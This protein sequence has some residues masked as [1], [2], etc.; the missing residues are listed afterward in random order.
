MSSS[1]AS[2]SRKTGD[3]SFNIVETELPASIILQ[4]TSDTSN[5]HTDTRSPQS[6]RSTVQ[7]RAQLLKLRRPGV[8]R[9]S[10]T[11]L[12]LHWQPLFTAASYNHN[13]NHTSSHSQITFVAVRLP[14]QLSA[15]LL[16]QQ[17]TAHYLGV[18]KF[19]RFPTFYH[20]SQ[21]KTRRK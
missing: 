15:A 1:F 4:P 20:L 8:E 17:D 10:C 12:E 13:T 11:K 21:S 16:L 6:R 5:P 7:A 18:L 19:H 9:S 14:L 3:N 2:S